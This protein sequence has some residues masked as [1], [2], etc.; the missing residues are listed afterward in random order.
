MALF[1]KIWTVRRCGCESVERRSFFFCKRTS[2][3]LGESP[4]PSFTPCDWRQLSGP[5]ASLVLWPTSGHLYLTG[6]SD[7]FRD[8]HVMQSEPIR[9][10]LRISRH[11]LEEEA[12][13]S[14]GLEPGSR[15]LLERW[16][17]W[18][19]SQHRGTRPERWKEK[20]STGNIVQRNRFHPAWS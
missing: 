5:P 14:P 11:Y 13:F 4:P 16:S 17:A 10:N 6:H 15:Q 3:F 19:R 20:S 18:E 7:W 9:S 8:K 12:L 1:L 2:V